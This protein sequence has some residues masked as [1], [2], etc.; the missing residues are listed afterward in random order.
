MN[1]KENITLIKGFILREDGN[2]VCKNYDF[3]HIDEIEGKTF[4]VECEEK[5]LILCEKGFHACDCLGKTDMFYS[6]KNENHRFFDIFVKRAFFEN[7]EKFVFKSFTVKKQIRLTNDRNTGD[8]N[9]GNSNTSN[10]NTGNSN[11]GNSNTGDL[12]TGN[13]NTGYRNTGNSNTGDWNTGDWNTG[14]RNTGERNLTNFSSGFFAIEEPK[15][16]CFGKPTEYTH[17]EFRRK[18]ENI[19]YAEPCFDVLMQLPNA[20]EETVKRYLEKYEKN[21]GYL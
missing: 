14:D 15:A 10:S 11:T 8:Y 4:T 7:A 6:T 21:K 18:F 16:Y 20:D 5:D 17:D 13:S 12:N 9:T 19:I 1:F 3:G 2:L